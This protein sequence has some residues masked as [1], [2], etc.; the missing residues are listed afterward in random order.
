VAAVAYAR[1]ARGRQVPVWRMLL[2]GLGLALVVFSLN[3]PLETLAAHYLVLAH[4]LQNALIADWAPPL[5]ILGLTPEMRRALERRGG[6]PMAAVTRPPVA[7]AIWLTGWYLVHAT[8]I[9]EGFLRNPPLLNAEHAAL[10]AI[11]LIFWWPVL[12]AAREP[13]GE[14]VLYLLVAFVAVSFLGLAFTFI[15]RPFYQFYVEAPRVWGLSA[16][17]D[18]NLG[19]VIMNAEQSV[20][21]LSAIVY[22]LAVVLDRQERSAR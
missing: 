22:V 21:F 13:A 1:G 9:Y 18:Q 14:I 12:G 5:L 8:P 11:G 4:L 6:R 16:S 20:V 19:G 3:S 2:F 15:S 10:I 7:L 17:E